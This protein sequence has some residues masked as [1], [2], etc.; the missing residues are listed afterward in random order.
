[1]TTFATGRKAYAISDRSGQRFPYD[2]MVTEWNGSFV[3]TSEYEPK[4]PQLEPKV[5]GNDPQGLLNARPDRTEPLSVVLLAFNPLLST[6]GSSTIKINEPGHDKTTG[7]KI[8]FT[9]VNAING[10]TN[11]MLNTTLGFSLTVVDTNQYTINGQTTA[12][13]RGNFGD[14]PSVGPSAVALP[15]NAFK[16]TASSSTI[17]VNQPAH[18]KSTANTVKFQSVN[19]L[20]SFLTSSGFSQSVLTTSAGYSITVI[21]LDN[22]SFNA[23]SGTGSLTTTIGGGSATAETI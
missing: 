19:V 13:A 12:S 9:N 16:T 8:I 4:Q 7:D 2:E 22:Y 5:P 6:V 11:A 14:Q 3:H 17:Q 23:S 20:N 21:N 1:M 18:G 15:N 10:F